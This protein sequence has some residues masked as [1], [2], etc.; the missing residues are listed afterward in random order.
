MI[1]NTINLP[2]ATWDEW[3]KFQAKWRH[4]YSFGYA[5][6][7]DKPFIAVN[8]VTNKEFKEATLDEFKEV[9]EADAGEM[10]INGDTP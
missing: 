9:I 6:K 4:M 7:H 8:R 1:L 2:V 10:V 5:A 3:Q